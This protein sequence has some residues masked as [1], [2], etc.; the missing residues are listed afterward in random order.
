MAL[1]MMK[2]LHQL[3]PRNAQVI[4]TSVTDTD[5]CAT[6]VVFFACSFCVI[7]EI[8]RSLVNSH[9]ESVDL[10][11]SEVHPHDLGTEKEDFPRSKIVLPTSLTSK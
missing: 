2:Q 3:L 5:L 10:M 8:S 11:R 1:T 9:C 7:I 4:R 6:D